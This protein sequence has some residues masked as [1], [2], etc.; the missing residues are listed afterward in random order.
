MKWSYAI[1]WEYKKLWRARGDAVENPDLMSFL[2]EMGER[3]WEMVAIHPTSNT[4]AGSTI[5]GGV[6][7]HFK[8]PKE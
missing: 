1:G 2:Q 4:L 8:R 5:G 6:Q 3:G 7:F